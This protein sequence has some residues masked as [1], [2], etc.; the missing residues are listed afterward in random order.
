MTVPRAFLYIM[1]ISQFSFEYSLARHSDYLRLDDARAVTCAPIRL[2][3]G[4]GW[5]FYNRIGKASSTTVSKFL[6]GTSHSASAEHETGTV[7]H[8][9]IGGVLPGDPRVNE[10]ECW[11]SSTD[12][13]GRA[14]GIASRIATAARI[15]SHN[16]QDCFWEASCNTTIT[17][18]RWGLAVP[19]TS[20]HAFFVNWSS[21]ELKNVALP[22]K[23][24][25]LQVLRNGTD[26]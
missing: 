8:E 20:L 10:A 7:Y 2:E 21:P 9:F 1:L 25:M 24:V 22:P 23:P 3:R 17:S 15:A 12:C 18:K 13:A 6:L 26:R 5:I 4:N 16:R 19:I 11:S 14:Q